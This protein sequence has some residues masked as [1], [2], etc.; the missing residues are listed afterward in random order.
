M[1]S[2]YGKSIF[3]EYKSSIFFFKILYISC[4]LNKCCLKQ[5]YMEFISSCQFPRSVS[6]FNQK[7]QSNIK[8]IKQ[9]IFVY[10]IPYTTGNHTSKYT[11]LL[12]V[13]YVTEVLKL[14]ENKRNFNRSIFSTCRQLWRITA[15]CILARLWGNMKIQ[16]NAQI[17]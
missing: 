11:T 4:C 14:W 12:C 13:E 8:M 7:N 16:L 15:L 9:E 6:C 5:S 2:Q 17:K 3:Q 1:V 10:W